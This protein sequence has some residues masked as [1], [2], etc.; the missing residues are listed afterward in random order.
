MLD[1]GTGSGW[2]Y[3]CPG[4]SVHGIYQARILEW[5]S[6]PSPGTLPNAG[7]ETASPALAGGFFTAESAGKSYTC[8]IHY[9]YNK[10]KSFAMLLESS[11]H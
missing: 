7:I 6:F 3:V 1:E 8:G 9:L 5:L 10:M 2:M 4:S 11:G